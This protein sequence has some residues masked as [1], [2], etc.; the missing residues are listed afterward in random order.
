MCV[1]RLNLL[2]K[3]NVF[4]YYIEDEKL[5]SI[6]FVERS[7]TMVTKE[8]VIEE[9]QKTIDYYISKQ[10]SN[11]SSSCGG[12]TYIIDDKTLAELYKIIEEDL[13]EKEKNIA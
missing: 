6:K 12:C 4:I 3:C 1:L 5:T 7:I 9:V 2:K 10:Q 11:D 8:R 13:N